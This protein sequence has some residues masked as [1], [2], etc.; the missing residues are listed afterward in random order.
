MINFTNISHSKSIVFSVGIVLSVIQFS[1]A[2]TSLLNKRPAF[3]NE[4]NTNLDVKLD[5]YSITDELFQPYTSKVVFLRTLE[6]LP[7]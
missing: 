2:N 7:S 3:S 6:S 1:P 5:E 4:I